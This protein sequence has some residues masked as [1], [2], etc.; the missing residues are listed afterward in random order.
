MNRD[1][2][3]IRNIVACIA[4]SPSP[5]LCAFDIRRGSRHT[6]RNNEEFFHHL[7]LAQESGYLYQLPEHGTH[8]SASKG[9][10]TIEGFE[11]RYTVTWKG[12]DWLESTV[13]VHGKAIPKEEVKT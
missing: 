13:I 5:D 10:Y 8:L 6:G 4:E 9:L 2:N 12:H 11:K 3:I 7:N 1:M